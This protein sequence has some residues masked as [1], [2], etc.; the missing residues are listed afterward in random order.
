[1]LIAT[2]PSIENEQKIE[3]IFSHPQVGTVRFN[4]GGNKSNKSVIEIMWVLKELSMKYSKDLLLDIKGRQLRIEVESKN[5]YGGIILNHRL[6]VPFGSSVGLRNDDDVYTLVDVNGNIIVLDPVPDFVGKGQAVNIF[7]DLLEVDG[8]LTEEDAD[9]LEAASEVGIN[10]VCASFFERWSDF[11]SIRDIHPNAKIVLKIES[12]KGVEF[13]RD[14]DLSDQFETGAAR[15]MAARDDLSQNY[16]EGNPEVLKVLEEIARIDPSAILASRLMH[17][18]KDSSHMNIADMS[19][20][21]LMQVLGYK[22]FM[23]GD[24]ISQF[25]FDEAMENWQN[26]CRVFPFE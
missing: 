4:V 16:G 14:V 17:G 20:L 25:R 3:Q 21:R 9:Y 19:D 24:N 7:S 15:L 10:I 11:L 22:H 13:I 26:F 23:L 8:Y 12:K 2:L 1:M 6:S 18:L 5:N